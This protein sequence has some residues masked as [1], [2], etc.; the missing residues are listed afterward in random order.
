MESFLGML[1]ATFQNSNINSLVSI[2][3][4]I[5]AVMALMVLQTCQQV[6][7]GLPASVIMKMYMNII[8]DFSIGLVPSLGNIVDAIFQA[9]T[10]NAAV[11]KKFL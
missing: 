10:R 2:G 1:K 6:E 9:N 3:D 5:D 4:I 11:L 7:G 8:L